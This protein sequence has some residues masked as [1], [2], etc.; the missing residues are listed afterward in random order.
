MIGIKR[1]YI[2]IKWD[3]MQINNNKINA[4][5]VHCMKEK[6]NIFRDDWAQ[7]FDSDCFGHCSEYDKCKEAFYDKQYHG[8]N[9]CKLI[10]VPM[11]FDK[12]DWH[13]N[14]I[15]IVEDKS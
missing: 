6:W 15:E 9:H 10:V 8:E 14:K 1:K 3:K 4:N 2:N 5:H 13:D 7:G 11:P 12:I